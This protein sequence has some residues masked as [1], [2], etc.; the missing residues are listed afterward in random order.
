MVS[1]KCSCNLCPLLFFLCLLKR[2]RALNLDQTT[3]TIQTLVQVN[4]T[5]VLSAHTAWTV[6]SHV[7]SESE[8]RFASAPAS[9]Y[10][11]YCT[12]TAEVSKVLQTAAGNR[13]TPQLP[14]SL[15]PLSHKVLSSRRKDTRWGDKNTSHLTWLPK[16][17]ERFTATSLHSG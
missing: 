10:V 8:M 15:C 6:V 9:V 13:D 16:R 12:S 3:V 17:P 14:S 11:H 4:M 2:H 1:S 7:S 5:I